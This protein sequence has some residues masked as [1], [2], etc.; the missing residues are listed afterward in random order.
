MD[1]DLRDRTKL[2][3]Q[4]NRNLS[5]TC[6]CVCVNAVVHNVQMLLLIVT[7]IY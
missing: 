5:Q 1:S 3:T 7:A 6:V 4:I 2:G